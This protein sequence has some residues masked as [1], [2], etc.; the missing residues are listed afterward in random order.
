M[1]DYG[2]KQT[3]DGEPDGRVA[4]GIGVAVLEQ[5]AAGGVQDVCEPRGRA[6]ECG[7]RGARRLPDG[8]GCGTGGSG[9]VVDAASLKYPCCAGCCAVAVLAV[10]A[11]RRMRG[12]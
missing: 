9:G 4:G 5:E 8:D 6:D 1:A 2:G 7:E 3:G 10:Q 11:I 12:G